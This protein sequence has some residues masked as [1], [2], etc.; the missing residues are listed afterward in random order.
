STATSSARFAVLNVNSGTPTATLSAGTSGGL[1]I[2]A[3]G[4]LA[5]TAK[6]TLTLGDTNTGNIILAPGG[7]TAL[8]ASGSNLTGA[9][10]CTSTG[11]ITGNGGLTV[12]DSNIVDL[13]GIT[14]TNTV[15]EGFILPQTTLASNQGP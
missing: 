14:H 5:T 8:T 12:P 15:N 2:S 9:G 4:T 11:L 10:T 3:N 6:Q 7:T 13:S 1:Y